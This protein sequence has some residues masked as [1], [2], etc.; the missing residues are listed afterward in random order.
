MSV[1]YNADN[2]TNWSGLDY[3]CGY[4]SYQVIVYNDS[5]TVIFDSEADSSLSNFTSLLNAQ[6][7]PPDSTT[8][9]VLN[10][11]NNY[12]YTS[13]YIV[14]V[15]VSVSSASVSDYVGIKIN[16]ACY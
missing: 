13:E 14:Q 8:T 2:V 10:S 15:Q 6:S 11:T 9:L 12:D 5:N 4:P 1:K 7:N 3:F 16:N